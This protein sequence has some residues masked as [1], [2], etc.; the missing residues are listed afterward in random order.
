[1]DTSQPSSPNEPA[2]VRAATAPDADSPS[3]TRSAAAQ[4]APGG[5][6]SQGTMIVSIDTILVPIEI[7]DEASF[8]AITYA[9]ALAKVFNAS[10]ILLHVVEEPPLPRFHTQD[11]SV[12]QARLHEDAERQ[13]T[14]LFN[15]EVAP[16][17]PGRYLIRS[18][19]SC[20]TT[21][22]VAKE[23]RIDLV[24]ILT[25]VWTGLAKLINACPAEKVVRNA[26]C[27]VLVVKEKEHE[28]IAP[29]AES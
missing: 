16:H 21:V 15:R 2:V 13:M 28:F 20:E 8:K 1:M 25:H 7:H 18:G 17:A 3:S 14:A 5:T 22:E 11:D 6:L 27:P 24:V 29:A 26:P 4:M 9:V 12:R 10:V 19:R 23:L